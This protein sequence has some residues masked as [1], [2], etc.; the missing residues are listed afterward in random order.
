MTNNQTFFKSVGAQITAILITALGAAAFT[1]LQ[2]IAVSTGACPVGNPDPAQ[3]GMLGA[4]IKS[5][6]SAYLMNRGIV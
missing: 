6:H 3:A 4:V 1:F 2:S 5:A